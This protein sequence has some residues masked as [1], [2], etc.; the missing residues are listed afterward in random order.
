MGLLWL[1]CF[2]VG[3][4]SG[5]G[6]PRSSH[7]S[8]CGY[9]RETLVEKMLQKCFRQLASL[10]PLW[11]F[12]TNAFCRLHA[13]IV[14]ID[15]FSFDTHSTFPLLQKKT[16]QRKGNN[17]EQ[18]QLQHFRGIL[19]QSTPTWVG[20][21]STFW[22]TSAT[23]RWRR[24]FGWNSRVQWSVWGTRED[25]WWVVFSLLICSCIACCIFH[26]SSCIALI[27][28]VCRGCLP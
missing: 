26:V 19:W 28:Y 17:N 8:I 27:S 4:L 2:V 16:K 6:K 12:M 1:M 25:S 3:R 10:Y 21:T 23:L 14:C 9:T 22:T 24:S 18:Q 13:H 20:N 11:G 7:T 5:V 15:S